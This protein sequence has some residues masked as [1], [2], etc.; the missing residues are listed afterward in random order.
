GLLASVA[1]TR[2]MTKLLFEVS[3]TDFSTFAL[4]AALLTLVAL[5]ACW[6]PARRATKVDP[7]VALRCE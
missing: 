6:I 3:A 5:L 2:S 4:I 7:M 1:L